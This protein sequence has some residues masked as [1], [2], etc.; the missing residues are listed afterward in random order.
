MR[1]LKCLLGHKF[2]SPYDIEKIKYEND[3]E[4]IT[5]IKCK[6]C[7]KV[8]RQHTNYIKASFIDKNKEL[9]KPETRIEVKTYEGWSLNNT[10]NALWGIGLGDE[11][12]GVF[13]L[14]SKDDINNMEQLGLFKFIENNLMTKQGYDITAYIYESEYNKKD[15]FI[16]KKYYQNGKDFKCINTNKASEKLS[17]YCGFKLEESEK[18]ISIQ[19]KITR[20][21]KQ[22]K[23]WR[24][25][26]RRKCI[27]H[28]YLN[29]S[30]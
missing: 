10:N 4:C 14:V 29:W 21:Y 22:S 13:H 18:I 15:N 1:K 3:K 9:P 2:I 28:N 8:L 30:A 20:R 7:G 16:H 17:T 11:E 26:N 6:Y 25:K 27:I 19:Y 23:W 12:V 5:I 24:F